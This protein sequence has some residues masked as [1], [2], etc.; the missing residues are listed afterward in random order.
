MKGMLIVGKSV[1]IRAIVDEYVYLVVV[2]VDRRLMKVGV[3]GDANFRQPGSVSRKVTVVDQ[4]SSIN[5]QVLIGD[6]K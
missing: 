1:K 6:N 5:E 4:N 3:P 2:V